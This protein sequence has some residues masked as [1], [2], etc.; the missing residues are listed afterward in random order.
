[1]STLLLHPFHPDLLQAG[2]AIRNKN[3][4]VCFSIITADE[5]AIKL[6]NLG[7]GSILTMSTQAMCQS[8]WVLITDNK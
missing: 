5:Y 6:K 3:T 1:M 4:E 7:D 2:A 8:E